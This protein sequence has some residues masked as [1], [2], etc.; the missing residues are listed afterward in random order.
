MRK[1]FFF[2]FLLSFLNCFAKSDSKN[3]YQSLDK[4]Q[5]I[6]FLGDRIRY[7]NEEII[8][9]SKAFFID[10]GLSEEEASKYP[11]VFNSFL[12][13]IKE[14]SIGTESEP[15]MLYIAPWVYWL[16]NPD[17]NE[18]RQGV[19][20]REPIG[21]TINCPYLHIKGLNSNPQ[22]I[23]LAANRGQTHG[24][25]GNFTMV[26]FI[27]DGLF[28]E[29]LTMGNFCNVDLEY[30]LKKDLSRQKRTSTTT[31]A[32]VAYCKG[33]KIIARNV[34]FIS[35]LNMNPLGGARRILFDNCHMEST[36]DALVGTGVYLNCT[37]DFYGQKP[38]YTTS[39][40][41]ATFLNS[42]FRICGDTSRLYFCKK[43]G[44]LS[45]IDCKFS[46]KNSV[47]IGWTQDPSKYLRCY[48]AGVELNGKPYIIGNENPEN[49]ILLDSISYLGAFRLMDKSEVIYNVYN[50]L[51][52]SDDWD[53]LNQ[54]EKIK[55]ISSLKG[56]DYTML[57]SSIEVTAKQ[58]FLRT[59]DPTDTLTAKAWRAGNYEIND[60]P[61]SFEVEDNLK[62]L[63]SLSSLSDNKC[64]LEA[65]NYDDFTFD[66]TAT[67]ST[68]EGA[69]GA[70]CLK[71]APELIE[72][73]KFIKE[74]QIIISKG[75]AKLDYKLD[76]QGREDESQISWYRFK[77]KSLK[78][79]I[80]VAVSR[81]NKPLKTYPLTLNDEGY[82]LMSSIIPR[83]I[84]SLPISPII[85][86]SK[87]PIKTKDVDTS[88]IIDTDFK[89]FPT[90][91]QPKI[92]PGFWTLD[93]YKP[94]EDSLYDWVLS[95]D[96]D[97]WTYQEGING[98]KGLGLLQLHRGARML[99]TPR[100][101]NYGNMMVTLEVA[102]AKT[103]GQGFNSATGQYMDIYIKFDTKTLSGYGLRIERTTKYSNAVD[104]QLIKYDNGKVTPISKAISSSCF[105]SPCIITL[106]VE[107][108]ELFAHAETSSSLQTKNPEL[109]PKIDLEAT[110]FKNNYGG[111]G[112][113]Y[114]GSCGEAVISL[115][116]LKVEWQ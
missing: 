8:L 39:L 49:T 107:N 64:L 31:Q 34:R 74:P 76:L 40:G 96:E 33:D 88:Y 13:A 100:E 62:N 51:R 56:I 3:N 29:N 97:F 30:P 4:T 7:M 48:Q 20:G 79:T 95:Q 2:F 70:V 71:I 81:D 105:I 6:E 110:I 23:V 19:N 63:V 106:K 61:F 99:F 55:E 69:Q 66:V 94:Q 77:D 41:G 22:N 47:Y 58:T 113:L 67:A 12:D 65:Q 87:K 17:D 102:P 75:E 1:F 14:L 116:R 78:D 90:S 93:G 73:P 32:H 10:G 101:S 60:I 50:L 91:N 11:Y 36:D 44:P 5:K 112:I 80:L 85:A 115:R 18:I 86:V 16:D 15:M 26:E 109:E 45:I 9:C 24:A 89:N 43:E 21:I 83:H 98:A 27:G 37:L 59:Q 68:Q 108:D 46:S 111:L 52:G 35:R 92:I 103:A 72:A 57:P 84:R 25:I 28:I 114:T 54:K 53:P 104:F 42:S 38:F 82:Y